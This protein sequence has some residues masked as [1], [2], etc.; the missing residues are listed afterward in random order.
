MIED[1]LKKYQDVLLAK[2]KHSSGLVSILNKVADLVTGN[3]N[4]YTDDIN[5]KRKKELL[6][7]H[8]IDLR[9]DIK[10]IV[11]N[12]RIGKKDSSTILT[13]KILSIHSSDGYLLD[14]ANFILK[15]DLS[16]IVKF[17]YSLGE[18]FITYLNPFDNQTFELK[19]PINSL[20][21]TDVDINRAKIK[22]LIDF[23]NEVAKL[24]T[25]EFEF[26]SIDT[27]EK[28]VHYENVSPL[29]DYRIF[30]KF[31]KKL[32]DNNDL[33]N[34]KDYINKSKKYFENQYGKISSIK[35]N[36]IKEILFQGLLDNE[37]LRSDY[38]HQQGDSYSAIFELKKVKKAVS[39]VATK[40]IDDAIKSHYIKFKNNFLSIPYH[41]RRVIFY[42]HNLPE[43][44]PASFIVLNNDLI[45][46]LNFPPG[47]PKK[48]SFYQG[49]PYIE[50]SYFPIEEFEEKIIS[51]KINELFKIYRALG[52]TKIIYKSKSKELNEE[53]SSSNLLTKTT[54]G[55]QDV[56]KASVSTDKSSESQNK[57]IEHNELVHIITH[58]PISEPYLPEDLLWINYEEDWKRI[59]DDR[60]IGNLLSTKTKLLSEKTSALS[61]KEKLEISSEVEVN[62]QGVDYA[63]SNQ[64]KSAKGQTNIQENKIEVE[65]EVFFKP[66]SKLKG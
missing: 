63:L 58:D 62:Y 35:L 26:S 17:E 15:L 9:T 8:N 38:Y 18:L 14:N 21:E 40:K 29:P 20:I 27:I 52:A 13:E 3:Y 42:T 7:L 12:D 41:K 6:I 66:K 61:T 57:D 1:I 30:T 22:P 60:L 24:K 39:E 37:L 55:V 50:S 49:H 64:F 53:L 31:A 46:N 48:N 25:S 32:L 65:I 56:G 51:E 33:T 47:H 36:P 19:L 23:L 43:E 2:E 28:I 45:P 11:D 10:L 59:V 54:A 4:I 5:D 44:R 16:L 34:A